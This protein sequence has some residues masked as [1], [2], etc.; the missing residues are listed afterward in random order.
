CEAA[1]DAYGAGARRFTDAAA[2]AAAVAEAPAAAAIVVK[3]SR[4]M[5]M[6]QVVAALQA[7]AAAEGKPC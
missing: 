5:K 7:R 4:F 1:A 2:L 3:G 6:E